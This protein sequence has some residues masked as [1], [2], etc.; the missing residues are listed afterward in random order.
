M[1]DWCGVTQTLITHVRHLRRLYCIGVDGPVADCPR[2]EVEAERPKLHWQRSQKTSRIHVLRQRAVP[3]M[4]T[5]QE[6]QGRQDTRKTRKKESPGEV[7]GG[8]K[9]EKLKSSLLLK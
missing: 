5:V 3:G 7:G 9:H 4:T 1:H 6:S 2:D 8:V